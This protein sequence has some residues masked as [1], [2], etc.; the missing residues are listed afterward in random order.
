MCPLSGDA[1]F[2]CILTSC[3]LSVGAMFKEK[4]TVILIYLLGTG[5]LG[6]E[7]MPSTLFALAY[8]V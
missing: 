3:C 2:K 5:N 1:M 8:Y 4:S 6:A 7:Y